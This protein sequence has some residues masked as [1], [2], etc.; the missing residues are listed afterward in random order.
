MRLRVLLMAL[1]IAMASVGAYAPA[2]LAD[3]DRSCHY[4][5]QLAVC[6]PPI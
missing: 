1:A 5:G 3:D 6:W 2:A 4:V